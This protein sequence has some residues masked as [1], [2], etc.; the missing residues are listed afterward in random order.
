MPKD[1]AKRIWER[2]QNE[3]LTSKDLLAATDRKPIRIIPGVKIVKIGGQS[4]TDRGRAALYPILDEIVENRRRGKKIML[5]SGGGT[6]A[7]HAYQIALDLE[8]PSGFL[9]AVGGPIAL[10]NARMLQML[11]AKHGG[12]HIGAEQFEML[13]LFFKLGCIP[14]MLGMPPYTYWEEIPLKGSIP[15]NR[16]DTGTFLTGEFL[17]ADSVLYIKD[18]NGLYTEDPKKNPK[19]EFIPKITV[20]ELKK[21]DLGD[22]VVERVVLEYLS[23]AKNIKFIE[24]FN[25]LVKGNVT[26]ALSGKHTGTRIYKD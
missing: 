17:G 6:R 12:I 10:Q 7:R 24:I 8:L 18:E 3:S 11:L 16:T 13:P 21:M 20:S 25:G 19:A 26:K 23:R 1:S 5:F 4:I 9:A 22:L 15:D 14:I 2:F